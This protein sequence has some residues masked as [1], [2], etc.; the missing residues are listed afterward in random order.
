MNRVQYEEALT[1]AEKVIKRNFAQKILNEIWVEIR[2]ERTLHS[3]DTVDELA[4]KICVFLTA[5]GRQ[6][7]AKVGLSIDEE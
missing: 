6:Y 1:K 2:R 5:I 7:G 3:G 4:D